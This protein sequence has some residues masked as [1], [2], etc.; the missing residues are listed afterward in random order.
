M[1]VELESEVAM[2]GMETRISTQ[3]LVGGGTMGS[4]M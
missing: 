3:E 2:A 1:R 4:R